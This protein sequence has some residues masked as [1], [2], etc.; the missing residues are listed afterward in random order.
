MEKMINLDLSRVTTVLGLAPTRVIG[1]IPL[2]R[3]NPMVLLLEGV[4]QP[5]ITSPDSGSHVV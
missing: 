1:S 2:D 4:V 5:M 3:C